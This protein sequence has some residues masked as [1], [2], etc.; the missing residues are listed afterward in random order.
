MD[1]TNVELSG[2]PI[3]IPNK[4]D[5]PDV[6]IDIV[7]R[8]LRQYVLEDDL[9]NDDDLNLLT[10]YAEGISSVFTDVRENV[11]AAGRDYQQWMFDISPTLIEHVKKHQSI[12][13]G[14]NYMRTDV[15]GAK[16]WAI[17]AIVELAVVKKR[18]CESKLELEYIVRFGENVVGEIFAAIH[19]SNAENA[20]K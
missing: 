16:S 11:I 7:A 9:S 5:V 13:N 17:L 8:Q 6:L 1:S 14:L 3:S 19:A 18:E 2:V 10:R 12:Y 4:V 20:N 15:I